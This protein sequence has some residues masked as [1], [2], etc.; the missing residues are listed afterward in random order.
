MPMLCTG[1]KGR[2]EDPR[3]QG[4]K[5]WTKEGAT[6]EKRKQVE[7][8]WRTAAATIE[9]EKAWSCNWDSGNQY[10]ETFPHCCPFLFSL[11]AE[12]SL[13]FQ[14]KWRKRKS[15][16][17]N[18]VA[19]K[20]DYVRGKYGLSTNNRLQWTGGRCS[21]SRFAFPAADRWPRKFFDWF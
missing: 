3:V 21:K 6:D 8:T 14:R 4:T 12:C 18:Q 20:E 17:K 10:L 11:G 7:G 9:Q 2:P 1:F 5:G 16:K 15:Q 13:F 19:I